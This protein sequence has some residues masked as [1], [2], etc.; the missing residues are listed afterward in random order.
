VSQA[1]RE[2]TTEHD[3]LISVAQAAALLGVHP[4]TIR[5]WTEAGRL[6]A[7]RINARGDRRYRRGDVEALLA[8][9][10]DAIEPASGEPVEPGT[11]EAEMTV[12][13][14]LAQGSGATSSVAAVCRTAIEALRGPLELP[15]AAI[16]LVRDG[17]H[18]PPML[19]T[20]AGYRIAPPAELP[21]LERGVEDVANHRR[22]P[23][24]AA[25]EELGVL[26]LE[27]DA[28]GGPDACRT[29][30]FGSW[31]EPSPA[32]S[33]TPGSWPAPVAR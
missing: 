32:T 13:V 3:A 5:V 12:L 19:E 22:V 9:G 24:R 1:Q 11:P 18:R 33:S 17:S 15:R 21:V 25:G 23:L 30:S 27:D 29:A 4:N 8:E 16:Y 31:P 28:G 10:A 7:Y 2:R 20:H 26:V 6:A 14:R